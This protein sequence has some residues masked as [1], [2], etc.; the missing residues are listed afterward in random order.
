MQF[1]SIN[2]SGRTT[3]DLKVALTE[4]IARIEQG[5]QAE[6]HVYESGSFNYEMSGEKGQFL[7]T[8]EEG[9]VIYLT[10]AELTSMA[11]LYSEKSGNDIVMGP[12]VLHDDAASYE[13]ELRNKI[14]HFA[15]KQGFKLEEV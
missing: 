11:D 6:F 13:D 14:Y 15:I 9:D 12:H 8:N 7:A 3:T 10:R 4:V 1:V 2:L 5:F